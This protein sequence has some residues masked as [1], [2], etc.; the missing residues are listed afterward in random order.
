VSEAAL[1]LAEAARLVA[2]RELSPV[3]L[4]GRLLAR[5]AALDRRVK[6][7]A[8]SPPGAIAVPC[9]ASRSR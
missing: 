7:S 6:R 9:T 2:S 8:R 4:V 3:D 1:T 5:I